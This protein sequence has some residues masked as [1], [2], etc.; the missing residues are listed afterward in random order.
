MQGRRTQLRVSF[1][2]AFGTVFYEHPSGE[3]SQIEETYC[4]HRDDNED[5][6]GSAPGHGSGASFLEGFK[7][8]CYGLGDLL[9]KVRVFKWLSV[10][11]GRKTPDF[12]G[13]SGRINTAQNA[14]GGGYRLLN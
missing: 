7:R 12:D 3:R 14:Y 1:L 10:D 2:F 8:I 9:L 5:G 4:K 11:S 13:Y 6:Y